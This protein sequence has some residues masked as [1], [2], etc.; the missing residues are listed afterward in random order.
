MKFRLCLFS[1]RAVSLL[2]ST[3]LLTS[4]LIFPAYADVY[5]ITPDGSFQDEKTFAQWSTQSAIQAELEHIDEMEDNYEAKYQ[6]YLALCQKYPEIPILRLKLACFMQY[7]EQD[8][9]KV[10]REIETAIYL[11]ETYQN[12]ENEEIFSAFELGRDF[13][14]SATIEMDG[15]YG[16]S[17]AEFQRAA[18]ELEANLYLEQL[19]Q[20]EP[21]LAAMRRSLQIEENDCRQYFSDEILNQIYS[22]K[23]GEIELEGNA[24]VFAVASCIGYWPS[25]ISKLRSIKAKQKELDCI[26]EWYRS[27]SP[28]NF[29]AWDS[30]VTVNY[31]NWTGITTVSVQN[32]TGTIISDAFEFRYNCQAL[33]VLRGLEC[34]YFRW[35]NDSHSSGITETRCFADGRQEQ[36]Q[37]SWSSANVGNVFDLCTVQELDLPDLVRQY[38]ESKYTGDAEANYDYERISYM[39]GYF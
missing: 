5:I 3:I 39:P 29:S 32:P 22:I 21:Y 15:S 33:K 13:G 18:Y 30:R 37:N 34:V 35:P 19:R 17:K 2:L 11:S 6:A 26:E 4:L 25:V 8:K 28:V 23:D 7:K 16:Y 9:T 20:Q 12:W 27:G 14:I 36:S 31:N 10:L 1:R 38:A 24:D